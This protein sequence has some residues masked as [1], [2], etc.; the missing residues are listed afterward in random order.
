KS[1][2]I[3]YPS[4]RRDEDTVYL[5]QWKEKRYKKISLDYSYLLVRCFHGSN[6]WERDHFLRRLRN[7]PLSFVQYIWHANIRRNLFGHPKFILTEKEKQAFQM[8]L[9]NSAAF[10]LV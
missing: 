2:E 3:R 5:N 8:F 7:S 9:E 4:L 10:N 6:T 1:S